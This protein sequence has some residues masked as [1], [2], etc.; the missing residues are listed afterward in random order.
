MEQW[1]EMSSCRIVYRELHAKIGVE[2][3]GED[4]RRTGETKGRNKPKE[5]IN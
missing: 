2:Y 1:F 5:E 4:E 3:E